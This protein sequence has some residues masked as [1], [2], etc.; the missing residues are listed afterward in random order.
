MRLPELSDLPPTPPLPAG[1]TV[2]AAVPADHDQ[3]SAVLSE[4]FGDTWDAAR[5]AE[6]FSPGN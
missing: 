4:A 2:R 5:V 3:I 1:Y 6:E